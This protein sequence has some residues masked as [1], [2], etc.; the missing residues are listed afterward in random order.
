MKIHL[1]HVSTF[2]LLLVFIAVIFGI[3][4]CST[5][6]ESENKMADNSNEIIQELKSTTPD[7]E[8]KLNSIAG[9]IAAQSRKLP[10]EVVT[11]LHSGNED[12]FKRA[13]SVLLQIG[14]LT[15]TPLLKS[16]S[17]DN[18]EDYVWDVQTLT[19][20]QMNNRHKLSKILNAMLLDTREVPMPE[21]PMEE[22][23]PIPRRVCDEA[24]LMLR[25][26]LSF[27]ETDDELFLNSQAYME[28]SDEE[29]DA[30]IKRVKSSKRWIS[31]TEHFF[32]ATEE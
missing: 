27:E 22:E 16:H 1:E 21:N 10:Q 14:D 19:D 23:Q 24:Y 6:F 5:N 31:L 30:E 18:P 11:M 8:E 13:A 2:R 26:L 15:F 28:L 12:D 4:N 17:E 29:R 7:D 25:N 20:I 32:D 3:H 9:S